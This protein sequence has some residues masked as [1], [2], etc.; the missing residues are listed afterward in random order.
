MASLILCLAT[1]SQGRP[2][3]AGEPLWEG[4]SAASQVP[5]SH[6]AGQLHRFRAVRFNP[7]R[8]QQLAA[9]VPHETAAKAGQRPAIITLPMPDGSDQRFEIVESLV[10]APELARRFPQIRTYLVQS[11]DDP[12]AMVRFDWSPHGFHA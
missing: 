7:S 10:M 5:K 2:G 9:G 1:R 4:G 11:L 12:A 3:E 8:W 6:Q